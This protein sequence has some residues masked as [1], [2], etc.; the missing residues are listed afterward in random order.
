MKQCP[1]CRNTYTDD[2]LRYCLADGSELLKI[3]TEQETVA[4]RRGE[5]VR[6]DI[7]RPEPA[8]RVVTAPKSQSSPVVKIVV[9]IAVIGLLVVM[10]A[11]SIGALV[12]FGKKDNSANNNTN[13]NQTTNVS[14]TPDLEKQRLQDQLANIQKRLDEQQKNANRAGFPSP[15]PTSN[16]PGVIT[17]RVNSPND[18]FLA[19]R[20]KPDADK[21][22]RIAKIPH[23]STITIE[24][25]D[26]EKIVIGGRSGRWCLVT[27][28]DYEG[29]VFDAWL[30]Y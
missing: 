26:R 5:Q 20:D 10:A 16:T 22:A 2:S 27:W 13:K 3:D 18:G 4:A 23:G 21:G 12:Y 8:P 30:I 7:G 14:P 24:N 1:Q 15:A 9:L 29:Y 6:V 25:C 19:L 17:A 28:G 11:A